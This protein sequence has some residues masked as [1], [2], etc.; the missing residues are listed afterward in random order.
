MA[1]IVKA[2]TA[3]EIKNGVATTTCTPTG[4]HDTYTGNTISSEQP[5]ITQIE[6]KYANRFDDESN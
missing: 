1:D 6:D 4:R 2:K 3:N 5:T